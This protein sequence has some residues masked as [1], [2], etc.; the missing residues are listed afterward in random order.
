V[1]GNDDRVELDDYLAET[2]AIQ[3]ARMLTRNGGL[4]AGYPNGE[5]RRWYAQ[6]LLV[7][8]ALTGRGAG[9]GTAVAAC[10]QYQEVGYDGESLTLAAE[11]PEG[12]RCHRPACRV[13][14]P[15]S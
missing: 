1:H 2:T 4:L 15:L 8:V 14:W 6:A 10:N 12:A 7:H 9:S 3:A 5:N 13:R 11:V